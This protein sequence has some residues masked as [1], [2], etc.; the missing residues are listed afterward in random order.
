[1]TKKTVHI[2]KLD[3]VSIDT[4]RLQEAAL[5][6][7][8]RL[9]VRAEDDLTETIQKKHSTP[10]Q[11]QRDRQRRDALM[12]VYDKFRVIPLRGESWRHSLS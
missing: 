11:E 8:N 9:Y 3:R 10:E 6:L 1:M 4:D 5:I 7:L 2:E 12:D